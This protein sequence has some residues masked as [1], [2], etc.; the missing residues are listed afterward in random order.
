MR[1]SVAV[2]PGAA[3]AADR[4]FG[5]VVRYA[6]VLPADPAKLLGS[7]VLSIV[8]VGTVDDDDP[9]VRAAQARQADARLK[10]DHQQQAER[11]RSKQAKN[12]VGK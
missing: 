11:Q 12:T 5:R 7:C 8:D 9:A 2:G 4:P 1:C 3:V 6:P 10:Q